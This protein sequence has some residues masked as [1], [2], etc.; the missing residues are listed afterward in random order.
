[1]KNLTQTQ[2]DIIR[3]IETEF[4]K[5]NEA[6]SSTDILSLIDNAI[7][8]KHI[9]RKELEIL[10]IHNRQSIRIIKNEIMETLQ[11]ICDKYEFSLECKELSDGDYYINLT[12]NGY[13]DKVYRNSV[14]NT[15]AIIQLPILYKDSIRYVGFSTPIF[16]G[17]GTTKR[18]ENKEEFLNYFVNETIKILKSNI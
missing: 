4:S 12:H 13:Y 6:E 10:D 15:R 7:N 17:Y 3:S 11:T 18:Y 2:N 14:L 9:L 16:M 5:I 1:M 8:E